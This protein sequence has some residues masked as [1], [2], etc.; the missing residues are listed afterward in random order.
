MKDAELEQRGP[1][2]LLFKDEKLHVS[3]HSHLNCQLSS[4]DVKNKLVA[5]LTERA[6]A[7]GVIMAHNVRWWLDCE[8]KDDGVYFE[9]ERIADEVPFYTFCG[10]R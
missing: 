8:V 4:W 5:K 9:G 10:I 7:I 3:E 6:A 2:R 1:V